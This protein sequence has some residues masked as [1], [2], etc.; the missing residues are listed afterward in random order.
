MLEG[1]RD[2][3]PEAHPDI[4][5]GMTSYGRCLTNLD[6]LDEAERVLLEAAGRIRVALGPN[7]RRLHAAYRAL[8][9]LYA[10]KGDHER[11]GEYRAQIPADETPAK[12]K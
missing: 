8:G 6:R 2:V 1:Y 7:H 12:V 9:D 3:L 5:I 10:A 11:A 4:A